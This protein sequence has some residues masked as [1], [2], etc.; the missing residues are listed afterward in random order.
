MGRGINH[1]GSANWMGV[2]V[3]TFVSAKTPVH[4]RY[5]FTNVSH[6][7]VDYEFLLTF[8]HLCQAFF[9]S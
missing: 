2:Q 3:N 8:F 9:V 4:A 7:V 5:S 6:E 1:L